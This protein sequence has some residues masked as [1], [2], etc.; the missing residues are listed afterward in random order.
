MQQHLREMERKEKE[1][2]QQ[3]EIAAAAARVPKVRKEGGRVG[4]CL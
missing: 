4:G 1:Q 2:R 3:E